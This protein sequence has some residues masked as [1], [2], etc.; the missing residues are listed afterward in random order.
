MVGAELF[1]PLVILAITQLIKKAAPAVV[2]WVT[3]VVAFVVGVVVALT[4][5]FI[6]VTDISIAQGV[7]FALTAIGISVAAAKSGGGAVGDHTVVVK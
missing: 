3:V 7:L 5:Q 1:I 4:D 2:G 6:G